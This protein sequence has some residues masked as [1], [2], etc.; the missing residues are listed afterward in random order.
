M[1]GLNSIKGPQILDKKL[2][3][4]VF[5]LLLEEIIQEVEMENILFLILGG[6]LRVINGV[7]PPISRVIAPVTHL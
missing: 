7:I 1:N 6:P 5:T 3:R 4:K 2:S